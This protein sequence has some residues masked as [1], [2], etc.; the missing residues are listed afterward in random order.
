MDSFEEAMTGVYGTYEK[1]Q[2][3]FNQ[4]KEISDRYVSDYKQIYELSKL[5]R[6]ITNSIDANSSVRAK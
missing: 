1:M 3:A 4:Q 5:N 6:D 2:E